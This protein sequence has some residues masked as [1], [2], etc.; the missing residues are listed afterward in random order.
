MAIW[1]HR[2][3]RTL[4]ERVV[5]TLMEVTAEVVLLGCLIGALTA[6]QGERLLYVVLGSLV[7]LPVVLFLHGYYFTRVLAGVLLR[8]GK[9]WLYP[10]IAATLFVIHTYVIFVRLKP[11]MSALGKAVEAPFLAGGAC[12][13]FACAFAVN[14]LFRK[15]TKTGSNGPELQHHEILPSSPGV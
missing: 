2:P 12:V 11:D 8:S 10:A 5:V 13:A 6:N 9:R 4:L 1:N 15:W 7:A 14:W 3:F